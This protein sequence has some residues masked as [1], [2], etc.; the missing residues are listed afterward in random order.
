MKRRYYLICFM[1]TALMWP[2]NCLRAQVLADLQNQFNTYAQT[3][4]QEKIFIHTDKEFYLAG[5][6]L[7]FKIYNVN[8]ADNGLMSVS[9]VAYIELLDKGN[10]P[11]LQ[12]K[13]SMAKGIGNGS[14]YLPV[15]LSS[16]TYKLRAYTNWMKNFDVDTYFEKNI[17]VVNSLKEIS[18][19]NP[20]PTASYDVQFFPEGGS[21]VSGINNKIAFRVVGADGLGVNFSG[22]IINSRNDTVARFSPHKFGMGNFMLRA[23]AGDTYRAVIRFRNNDVKTYT[24]PA[25]ATNGFGLQLSAESSPQIKLTVRNGTYSGPVYLIAHNRQNVAIALSQIMNNGEADFLIDKSKLD[26]G[27]TEL[28][29]FNSNKQPVA[30]RTF[31]KKPTGKHLTIAIGTDKADYVPR[32]RVDVTLSTKNET[33]SSNLSVA[34]YRLDSLTDKQP[35]S[36]YSYLQLT[37]NLHGNVEE[38]DYY[39]NNDDEAALDNLALTQGWVKYA[40]NPW[41]VNNP[42]FKFLPEYEGHIVTGKVVNP[43]TSLS[44]ANEM[45]LLSVPGKHV[46][47]YNSVTDRE[48][49]FMISTKNFIGQNEVILMPRNPQDSLFKILLNNPFS[50]VYSTTNLPELKLSRSL[51]NG[52]S[53]HNLAMQSQNLYYGSQ[54]KQQ[55]MPVIDTSSTYNG[56]QK[57]YLLDDY[58]R[59]ATMEEVLRENIHEVLVSKQ[60][61]QFK[62]RVLNNDYYMGDDQPPLVLYDGVPIYNFN[63]VIAADPLKVRKIDVIPAKYYLGPET[64]FGVIS[65]V[66]Y[67]GDMGGVEINPHALVLDYEGLQLQRAFFS[68]VYETQSQ[69][70]SHLPDF[71]TTLYWAPTVITKGDGQVSLSFYTSDQT[72]KYVGVVQGISDSGNSGMQ[73]FNFEVRPIQ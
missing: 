18:F 28:T 3:S 52:L 35:Q 72:G 65:M 17:A 32:R 58:T 9:K 37:S 51:Y 71:R 29:V 57:Q 47:L 61:D 14:L 16:G 46:Q 56:A 40:Q 20:N 21:L 64:E 63:K 1:I 13:V 53:V 33:A 7:W 67:K 34:V 4:P 50:T 15:A 6:L 44:V 48:G 43:A 25:I 73:V 23:E 5:E 8:A 66:T 27:V 62:F 70:N 11:V 49:N 39:I 68:P 38:P 31:I 69:I 2:C 42:G 59:Y 22:A 26:E 36:I 24:L 55:Y 54:I 10:N 19:Q 30:G 60:R 12:T 45:I 41:Q